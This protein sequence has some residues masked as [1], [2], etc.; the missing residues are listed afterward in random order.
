MLVK[1]E[2]NRMVQITRNVELFDKKCF[3]RPLVSER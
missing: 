1:F 3:L 2:H